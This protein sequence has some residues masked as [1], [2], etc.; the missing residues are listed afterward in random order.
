MRVLS[1]N[2]AL[3]DCRA[4]GSGDIAAVS[5]KAGGGAGTFGGEDSGLVFSEDAGEDL[6]DVGELA[7]DVEG[8]GDLFGP[9][10]AVISGSASM[11]WR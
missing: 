7:G 9:R 4:A 10:R 1:H 11:R 5:P 2:R 6:V 8:R 3:C